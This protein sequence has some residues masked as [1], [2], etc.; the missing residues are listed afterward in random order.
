MV[1]RLRTWVKG[2]GRQFD[3]GLIVAKGRNFFSNEE[4]FDQFLVIPDA[5]VHV[6]VFD[7]C[8]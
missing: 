5:Q 2:K 4:G 1:Y 3:W 8:R 6:T 7:F